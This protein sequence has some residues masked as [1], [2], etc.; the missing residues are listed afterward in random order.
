MDIGIGLPNVVPGTTGGEL[1]EWA[2]RAEDRGFSALATLDRLA[3]PSYDALTTLAAAAGAT[4]R[5]GLL[6]NILLAP[7]YA[8]VPLAKTTAALDQLSG[9]RLT[10][11][12]APGSRA[13]D[14]AAAGRDF[15]GRGAAFDDTLSILRQ[16]WRGQ[17]V[18]GGGRE[19]A[20]APVRDHRVPILIGGSGER[21]IRRTAE[22]GDGWTAGGAPPEAAGALVT[23][24]HAAWAEARR[25]GE[26]RLAC[27]AYFSLGDDA[28]AGSLAYLRDYYGFLGDY[29][30]RI[31]GGALRSPQAIRD[32]AAAYADVGFTEFYLMPTV[33]DPGQVDRLADVVLS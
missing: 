3:Y 28:E 9:G 27:L 12:M 13:D 8:P 4:S 2:R 25:D 19:P 6:T 23:R 30:D 5:I 14:F 10:L 1:L 22:W 18:N 7:V 31:A 11:G 21:A 33:S 24:I 29:A 16:A 32:A 17:A 26:P 20:P 15:A